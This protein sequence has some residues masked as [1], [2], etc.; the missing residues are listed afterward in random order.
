[1][2]QRVMIA[3]AVAAKP[4][5]LIADE[6]TTA[7]DVTVQAQVLDL[8]DRMKREINAGVLLVTHDLGVVAEVCDDV[9]VMYAGKI[10]E[11]A[12]VQTLFDKPLH[13]YTQGLLSAVKNLDAGSVSVAIPGQVDP[14]TSY[15]KGCRF[16]PRCPK[17]L[18]PCSRIEP[19]VKTIGDTQVACHL[20]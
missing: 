7:L 20:F 9:C 15:P 14:A 13:P 3:I 6:P 12:D 10:V 4:R 8:M 5:L 1:M 16:H 19:V 2:R 18:E 11:Q 17:A